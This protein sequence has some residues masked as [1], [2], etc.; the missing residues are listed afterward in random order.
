MR[1]LKDNA[2]GSF[3]FRSGW[4]CFAFRRAALCTPENCSCCCL[5]SRFF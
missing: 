1:Q 4:P 5:S 3:D 2:A